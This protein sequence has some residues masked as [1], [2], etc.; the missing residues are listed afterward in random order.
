VEGLGVHG[1]RP[2]REDGGE[3]GLGRGRFGVGLGC[4]LFRA[5][6]LA[7]RESGFR[8]KECEV[9]EGDGVDAQWIG[10]QS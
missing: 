3:N 4:P 10:Y 9:E 1:G 5:P 7:L 2:G 6:F 8:G